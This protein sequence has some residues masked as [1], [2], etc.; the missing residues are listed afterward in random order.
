MSKKRKTGSEKG[1]TVKTERKKE[2]QKSNQ[3]EVRKDVHPILKHKHLLP[4]LLFTVALIVRILNQFIMTDDPLSA[5]PELIPDAAHYHL[6][7]IKIA[8]GDINLTPVFF[9]GPLYSY[10]LGLIYALFGSGFV[11]PRIF[12]IIMGSFTVV[13]LWRTATNIKG[14][15]AGILTAI[16]AVFYYP[17]LFFE[18][19][20]LPATLVTFLTAAVLMTMS[21]RKDFTVPKA[22]MVGLLT[23]LLGL[24]KGMMLLWLPWLLGL[25]YLYGKQ[26]RE[27]LINMGVCFAVTVLM[28][29][30]ATLHNY[31]VGNDL[32][33]LSSNV[34]INFFIGSGQDGTG[35]WRP[36]DPKRAWI[37]R[38]PE[39]LAEYAESIAG[40][41]KKPSEVSRYW[42]NRTFRE[43]ASDPGDFARLLCIKFLLFW[44]YFEICNNNDYYLS[45]TFS[46]ILN[47]LS[48]GFG[49]IA[50]FG[51]I[52][53]II[54]RFRLRDRL[55]LA[56]LT[57]SMLL[58]ALIFFILARY[59]LPAVPAL[60]IGTAV[61]IERMWKDVVQN[62]WQ[63]LI[64]PGILILA[65]VGMSRAPVITEHAKDEFHAMYLTRLSEAHRLN[66]DPKKAEISLREAVQLKPEDAQIRVQL[67]T[68]FYLYDKLEPAE[69]E[70]RV[71][72]AL[73]STVPLGNFILGLV[74]AK[75]KNDREAIQAFKNEIEN[76]PNDPRAYYHLG[77]VLARNKH[78]EEALTAMKTAYQLNPQDERVVK[79]LGWLQYNAPKIGPAP[80]MDEQPAEDITEMDK[81]GVV[82]IDPAM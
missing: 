48:F 61:I 73:D 66:G 45:D 1:K 35:T 76:Y 15:A 12:H 50:P 68:L 34:G 21:S 26:R 32:V 77:R 7:G 71:A 79:A 18:R 16:M 4:L 33:L 2:E 53:L 56:G 23:G 67:A 27:R 40:E 47:F 20:L 64:F 55:L 24:T 14:T 74:S 49:F 28:L 22:A 30:P 19:Q 54:C 75:N 70:A 72:V 36:P 82:Y 17:F 63:K 65:A 42:M 3:A 60:M 52:G 44:N 46:P 43:I 5:R 29:L 37:G 51:L 41:G 25:I 57:V 8:S 78:Y 9:M 10:L 11:Q 58:N 59:R 80:E 62:K 38:S 81:Y 6:S 31:I 69:R 39:T 13:M